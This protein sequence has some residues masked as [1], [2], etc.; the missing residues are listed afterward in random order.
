[1]F[2]MLILSEIYNWTVKHETNYSNYIIMHIYRADSF[3]VN[4][5]LS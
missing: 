5:L 2:N 1:M 3:L 4:E